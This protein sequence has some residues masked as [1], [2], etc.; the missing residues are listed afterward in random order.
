MR[1][2]VRRC[3][4]GEV[5]CVYLEADAGLGKSTLVYALTQNPGIRRKINTTMKTP[6]GEAFNIEGRDAHVVKIQVCVFSWTKKS[7]IYHSL[8]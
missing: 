6:T 2:C 7:S 1:T 3:N 4:A 8:C 5:R